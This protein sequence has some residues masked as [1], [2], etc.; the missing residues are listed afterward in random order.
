MNNILIVLI[1]FLITIIIGYFFGLTIVSVIENKLNQLKINNIENFNNNKKNEEEKIEISNSKSYN[2]ITGQKIDQK[3]NFDNEYYRNMNNN[4][5]EGYSN[6][7]SDSF[8]S[9]SIEKKKLQV[10][11][12][13][14][15][16]NKEGRNLNCTYGVTNYA[17]PIDMSSM[18]YRIFN[19][20][21][22]PNMTLQDYIN[23]LYCFVGK[24]DE[25]PY[26]HLKNLAKIK[27]GKELIPEEGVLP[28]PPY[29]YPS[30]NAKDYFDKM[31]SDINE[32]NI[33]GPLN[34]N[35]G[36][37]IGYNYDEYSEFSQNSDLYGNGSSVRN[38][39]IEVK[40][41]AKELHEYV[42]PKDS[43]F[44]NETNEYDIYRIKNVEV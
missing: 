8:K 17:D 42:D 32:F 33:A 9:W 3:Y 1:T 34:S 6:N 27:A 21:Y 7:E 31:Y 10:C 4:I 44:L 24:E 25:L 2:N 20:N 22:P 12:K 23:W 15:V 13:N 28:P 29:Y 37:M 30:L 11:C 5:I 38:N 39:D 36:P 43:N 16:H 35:T 14:H 19:L 26:N 41:N 18:D 40:K